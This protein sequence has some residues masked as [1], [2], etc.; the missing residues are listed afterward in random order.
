MLPSP[1]P[2]LDVLVVIPT[3]NER[4]SLPVLVEGLRQSV[5]AAHL[6]VV[7]DNSPDG[8]GDL[9]EKLNAQWGA[10]HLL[11][12]PGKQGLGVAYRAGLGWALERGYPR[13][14]HMDADLSHDPRDVPRLLAAAQTA[15]LAIGSRYVTGGDTVGWPLRRKVLSRSAN[16][17]ART[18]LRLP[19]HDLTGGFKCW[20]ADVLRAIHVTELT[21]NGYVFMVETTWR[22]VRQGF[23][24]VEV[25]IVFQ[26]RRLGTSKMGLGL[27]AEGFKQVLKWSVE[28]KSTEEV[29]A[30][31]RPRA[32]RR[33]VPLDK[34]A[35]S[36]VQ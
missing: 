27:A 6:L 4:E 30:S 18:M 7:D 2:G 26:E 5:P 9:A 12:R 19:V 32:P 17:Y 11:R 10:V 20:H 16:L 21:S 25:P 33:V 36:R 29:A 28:K 35:A 1:T 14:V 22:A 23:R 8:T 13:I 31:S 34:T 15:D 24:P 3:Y